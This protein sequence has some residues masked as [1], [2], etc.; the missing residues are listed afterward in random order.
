MESMP[1]KRLTEGHSF[2]QFDC[3]DSDLNS[4]LLDDAINYQKQLLSVTY[5]VDTADKTVLFFS[6]SND[7]ITAVENSNGFWRKIKL[8]FPHS[9]HRKDYPAVKI[10]R[11]AVH[12]DFQHTNVHWGT[13]VLDF[14]K[15]W[16]IE[17]NKTGCRFITVDAYASA[18]PFYLKNGFN[19]M[20]TQEKLRYEKGDN[21][22]I[23]MYYDLMN[24][25]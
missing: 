11:F 6:L 18:V 5:Y 16:M 19:F 8:L 12:K 21:E 23:A 10:G 1:F 13:M 22:I 2:C 24:L 9:K 14:I 25:Q 4:F 3:G 7:K 15:Q 20:G 17:S